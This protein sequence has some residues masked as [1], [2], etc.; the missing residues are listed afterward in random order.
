MHQR[1]FWGS[2]CAAYLFLLHELCIWDII[3]D[4]FANDGGGQNRVYLLGIYVFELSIQD[5]LVAFG[6]KIDGHLSTE[7]D[8]GEDI[9][10]LGDSRSAIAFRLCK[11]FIWYYVYTPWLCIG[12]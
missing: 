1:G 12:I 10:I 8:K 11:Y 3:D 6:P 7:K 5:E 9:T 4:A 2:H